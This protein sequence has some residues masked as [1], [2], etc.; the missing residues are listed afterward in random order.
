MMEA[1][2]P[3]SGSSCATGS[4]TRPEICR[5]GS[6]HRCWPT[7]FSNKAPQ[8]KLYGRLVHSAI[9]ARWLVTGVLLVVTAGCYIGFGQLKQQFFPDSNTPLFF[10]H[11]KLPQ[12]NSIH[13]TS[14][15]LARLEAW[16]A[17]RD[18]V[19]S[20]NA[21]AGDGAA[22]FM[23]TYSAEKPNP[24][25]GHLVIRTHQ[26]DAFARANLPDG[27]FRSA[28]LAFGPGGGDPIQLRLSGSDP[29]VLRELAL[30]AEALMRQ[31]SPHLNGLHNDWREQE[32]VLKPLYAS[33]RAQAAG[34]TRDDISDSLLFATDGTSA[35]VYREDE[36]LIPIIVRQPRTSGLGLMDQVVSSSG[37]GSF[38]P[39]EQVIDGLV[40]EP[41]DTLLHRRNRVLTLTLGA[42]VAPGQTAAAVQAEIRSAVEAMPLPI[43]YKMEW[44]GELENSAKAVSGLARQLPISLI[45]MVLISV[46]LFSALRQPLIIWLLVPMS[47]NGVV[48]GLLLTGIPFSFTALL[49]LLGLS[50]MLIKNGI[51]LVEEIDLVRA[52]GVPLRDAIVT[53]CVSRL[54]P[55]VLAAATTILGM[56]PLLW[57]AFFV[58]MSVTIMAG[59]AFAS[60]LTLVA[61]PVFYHLLFEREEKRR[62]AASTGAG[63]D[64]PGPRGGVALS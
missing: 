4:A 22:R 32:L 36:R 56:A 57:D 2:C 5:K 33:E 9:T 47:V 63:S 15:H 52:E 31:A 27:E 17:T 50:G 18:E 38:L 39:I 16:L 3:R 6:A 28:R 54:R 14:E 20:V 24:S 53:A 37:T 42:D 10:A 64:V 19:V 48:V 59:L 51:V 30:T 26:L 25:Y 55:V 1:R 34:I 43:G 23:L 41:Q 13:T 35:G 7:T 61:V 62:V 21:F 49:G 12:G 46:F 11:Y 29:Q 8:A 60:V 40:F 45:V 58:S 44:G